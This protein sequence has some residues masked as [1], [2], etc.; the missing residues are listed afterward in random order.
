MDPRRPVA[1]IVV[2]RGDAPTVED[3]RPAR[4]RPLAGALDT[5]R[6][7]WC[8]AFRDEQTF[9]RS[10]SGGRSGRAATAPPETGGGGVTA[11]V[12]SRGLRP[13]AG[14]HHQRRLPPRYR[15][16]A[17]RSDR[18][19]APE[20]EQH[21]GRSCPT[22]ARPEPVV[23]GTVRPAVVRRRR[24]LLG[25]VATGLLVALALPWGGSGGRP[26]ATSGSA[27]AGDPIA[28]HALY[29][30]QPGDTLWTIAERLDPSGDPRVIVGELASRLGGD[31][32]RAGEQIRLP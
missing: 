16:I 25:I 13:S 10:P 2:A 11:V 30:V 20:R 3:G 1:P 27:P 24:V 28:A 15:P 32:I 23:R 17:A 7:S 14:R 22:Q 9:D 5:N 19:N 12:T 4:R 31:T 21:P 6:C 29:V 26:L 18:Q 8:D